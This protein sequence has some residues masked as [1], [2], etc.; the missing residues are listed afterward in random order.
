MEKVK[1]TRYMRGQRPEFAPE[2]SSEEEEEVEVTAGFQTRIRTTQVEEKKAEEDV[3]A[4]TEA[5]EVQDRRLRRLQQREHP[6]ED[7][8]DEDD[9]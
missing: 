9:R 1:V 4:E 5:Q 3:E 2:S 7:S 8:G 6:P